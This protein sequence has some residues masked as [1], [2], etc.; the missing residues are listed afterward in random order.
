MMSMTFIFSL[1]LGIFQKED[2]LRRSIETPERHTMLDDITKRKSA[3]HCSLWTT[4]LLTLKDLVN[5]PTWPVLQSHA[6]R[7]TPVQNVQLPARIT[8]PVVIAC[9]VLWISFSNTRQCVTSAIQYLVRGS[10]RLQMKVSHKCKIS[11][12][13]HSCH[14]ALMINT[15]NR[16]RASSDVHKTHQ[17]TRVSRTHVSMR[18]FRTDFIESH[19]SHQ[20]S[21]TKTPS[22]LYS[23]L[24]YMF[25]DI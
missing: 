11:H 10:E 24:N 4:L 18:T 13:S 3:F 16:N 14:V 1:A 7:E 2:L 12:R 20:R 22:K 15:E 17:F 8:W 9:V 21:A 19:L 23:I 6:A 25:E 5:S